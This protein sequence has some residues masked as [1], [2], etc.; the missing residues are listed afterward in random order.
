[1]DPQRQPPGSALATRHL[2][3]AGCQDIACIASLDSLQRQ[4]KERYDGYAETAA[5]AGHLPWL[6]Q[7]EDGLSRDEQGRRAVA[8]LIASGRS[9]DAVFA[10]CDEIALG[11][12]RALAEAGQRVPQDA[13]LIGFD[14]IRASA[15]AMPPLS[16]IEPDFQAAGAMLV[17][18]L[19]A[20]IAGEPH[21]TR[22][23]PVRLVARASTAR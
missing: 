2:L 17:D 9:F 6:V 1:M 18:K 5:A 23:V 22:R 15:Q 21:G 20:G 7:I 11:A 16:T 14:G 10:V 19:L 12:L 13:A 8:A 4:F 3:D